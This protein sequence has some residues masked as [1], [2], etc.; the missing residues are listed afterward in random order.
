MDV[1]VRQVESELEE[2]L[3]EL[4]GLHVLH[5]LEGRLAGNVLTG[6]NVLG[7]ADADDIR[8]DI[9]FLFKLI[10]KVTV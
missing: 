9:I 4:A 5:L 6:W 2:L 3:V 7:R 10:L 8:L 1:E